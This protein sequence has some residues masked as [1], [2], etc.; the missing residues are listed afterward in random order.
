MQEFLK[1]SDAERREFERATSA[2]C[3]PNVVVV[4][5]VVWMHDRGGHYREPSWWRAESF[6]L[7]L[8]PLRR[9]ERLRWREAKRELTGP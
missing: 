3:C 7:L 5:E 2:A 1:M 4:E 6:T 9:E 8:R